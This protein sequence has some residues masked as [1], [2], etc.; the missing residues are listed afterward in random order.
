MPQWHILGA[1]AIGC[2]MAY[3][4]HQQQQSSVLISHHTNHA[5]NRLL[6]V[7]NQQGQPHTLALP[8]VDAS[9][10]PAINRLLITTKAYQSLDALDS[11]RHCLQPNCQIVFFHNGMGPQQQALTEYS[12]HSVIW[13]SL[14]HGAYFDADGRLVH[15]GIGEIVTG[16]PIDEPCPTDWPSDWQWVSDIELRLWNKLAINALINPLTAIHQCRNGDL[17]KDNQLLHQMKTLATEIENVA[18]ACNIPLHDTFEQAQSVA[19]ITANNRSSMLQDVLAQRETEI[20]YINGFIEKMA[21]Q[22]SLKCPHNQQI[23]NDIHVLSA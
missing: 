14:T 2:L 22:H 16:S 23:L 4:L 17:L 5:Q 9:Q 20:D 21:Q 3:L 7:I 11:V 15:A 6:S 10:L 12:Q 18:H 1:G 19:R 8:V 13:G